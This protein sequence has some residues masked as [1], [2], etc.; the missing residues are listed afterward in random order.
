LP[1][2]AQVSPIF[3]IVIDD[4]DGDGM[5]DLFLGGNFYGLK[6]EVGRILD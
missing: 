2:E 4:L 1:V 6:P 5:A 3:T